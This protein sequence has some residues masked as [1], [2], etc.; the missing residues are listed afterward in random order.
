MQR[1][2]LPLR[3]ER[4]AAAQ[5]VV[6][7]DG[8]IARVPRVGNLAVVTGK[9]KEERDLASGIVVRKAHEVA[10]VFLVHGDDAVP[11]C[12]VFAPYLLCRSRC[13]GD[14]L[15]SQDLLRAR[16]HV[17]ADLVCAARTRVDDEF[18]LASCA[19]DELLHHELCHRRAADVAVADE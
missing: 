19:A 8:E 11:F 14:A 12:I 7:G 1:R 17:A 6:V 18:C 5:Y 4:S 2:F 15:F 9:G 3:E 13:E 10:H 16:M